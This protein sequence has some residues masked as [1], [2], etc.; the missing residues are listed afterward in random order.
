[1]KCNFQAVLLA[2]FMCPTYR[3]T[4]VKPANGGVYR[5]TARTSTG[6]YDEDYVLAIQGKM[7]KL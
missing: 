2:Y 1:M 7:N 4:E 5:C 6:S 3:V